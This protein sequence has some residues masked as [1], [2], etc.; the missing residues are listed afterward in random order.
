MKQVNDEP[1]MLTI[2]Q[3]ARTGLLTEYALR[4]LLRKNRLPVIYVGNRALINYTKLCEQ[5]NDG[6]LTKL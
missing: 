2:R 5:L 4:K 1:Y 6:T 3:V